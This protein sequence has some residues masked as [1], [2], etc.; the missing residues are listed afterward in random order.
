[1]PR[2]RVAIINNGGANTASLLDALE[3][4]GHDGTVTRDPAVI[5]N[6]T[7]VILPG[8]GSATDAM[9]RLKRDRLDEV[10]VDLKQPVL[11]IC[12]GLQLLARWSAEDDTICLG[13]VRGN[14]KKLKV[15]P[16][17]PV[18]NTG[19]CTVHPTEYHPLFDGINDGSFFYFVHSYA[20]P[21]DKYTLATAT[22]SDRF[23][24]VLAQGNFYAS[25]FHPERSAEAGS[26]FLRNFLSLQ[27]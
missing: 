16:Q 3:R 24:A 18:P 9:R 14:V 27:P 15:S 10:I 19:W 17:T 4:L 8:V 12:L 5:R 11:G 7:H 22:H 26:V 20:L 21:V 13:L 6:A 23:T 1:M 2:I 25:Q